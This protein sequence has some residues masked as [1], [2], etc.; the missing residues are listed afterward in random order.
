MRWNIEPSGRS[1]VPSAL[2]L[3]A[4]LLAFGG[5]TD[6]A[7]DSPSSAADVVWMSMGYPT[8]MDASVPITI[9]KVQGTGDAT[10][11][12]R[13]STGAQWRGTLTAMDATIPNLLSRPGL[14]RDLATPCPLAVSD[15]GPYIATHLA[16]D[17]E[18]TVHSRLVMGSCSNANLEALVQAL[19]T[20]GDACI[21][22]ASVY[23][24]QS[25]G[26]VSQP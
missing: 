7:V 26:G 21:S 3:S 18:Q 1:L 14:V 5:C 12:R 20:I 13:D 6:T 22:T 16:S 2:L 9:V 19:V 4:S 15:A 24:E 8:T 10:C 17:D 23:D 11:T 25:D